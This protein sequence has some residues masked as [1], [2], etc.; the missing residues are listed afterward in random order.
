[1]L[2]FLSN[3]FERDM[4]SVLGRLQGNNLGLRLVRVENGRVKTVPSIGAT[5]ILREIIPSQNKRLIVDTV[6]E[7]VRGLAE[8][9]FSDDF[10]RQMFAQLMR[11]SILVPVV[12]DVGERNR[13][14]DN[15]SQVDYCRTHVLF[16]IQ[17]HM[18]MVDQARFLEADTYLKRSYSE[19]EAYERRS[20][21]PYDRFQLEDRKAKF[22]MIRDRH[23]P[24]RTDFF[25][26]IR[27][28]CHITERLMRREDLTHHPF[29]TLAEIIECFVHGRSRMPEPLNK[30]CEQM[31]K[32]LGLLAK[33][34]A[35]LLDEGYPT[36]RAGVAIERFDRLIGGA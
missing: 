25:Y 3:I 13:F 2:S 1:M 5:R 24:L 28:A 35:R 36:N 6:V 11:Y 30:Q 14:F 33:N 17:W 15:I 22:L 29:D 18:A 31:I 10:D 20:G 23:E 26:D 16:W 7:M 4:G 27:E 9:Q 21:R 34:R 32:R 19:A 8:H 12:T